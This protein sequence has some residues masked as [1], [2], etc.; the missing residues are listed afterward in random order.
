MTQRL[1]LTL[2]AWRRIQAKH[3]P[4]RGGIP[5]RD[6]MAYTVNGVGQSMMARIQD[7]SHAEKLKAAVVPPPIF[8]LGFWRSGT[9]FLH[10]LISCDPR[11]GYP[12]TFA[13]LNPGQFLLSESW[14]RKQELKQVARP[15]DDLRYSW[16][17]PQEDEFALLCMG[18]PSPYEAVIAPSL[19]RHPGSLVDFARFPEDAQ[20]RWRN[21]LQHFLCLLTVQQN[22]PMVLKSPP[23]GFRLS[24]L[25]SMFPGAR[26]ILI[27]RNP[28]EVFASNLKLWRTLTDLYSLEPASADEMEKFVLQAYLLHEQALTAGINQARPGTF[29]RIRYEELLVDAIGNVKRLYDELQLGEFNEVRP[30]LEKYLAGVAGHKRNRFQIS[31]AQKENLES[32]WG[33]A[34]REKGYSLPEEYLTVT[35]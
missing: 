32:L 25:I 23:H 18:A 20:Q 1:R 4:A 35:A 9:T 7:S 27:E 6:R 8:L 22:K 13:C 31:A 15:M 30:H 29:A 34:I 16:V 14:I 12:S 11:F 3:D 24:S 26:F 19:F 2:A 5:L 17:S 28:F 10:E 33:N 21:A